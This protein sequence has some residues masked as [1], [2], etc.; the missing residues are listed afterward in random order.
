[1]MISI[2]V[3][4]TVTRWSA[5]CSKK[6]QTICAKIA[7]TAGILQVWKNFNFLNTQVPKIILAKGCPLF[8]YHHPWFSYHNVS[9]RKL[10]MKKKNKA[11]PKGILSRPNRRHHTFTKIRPKK[12]TYHITY[13][14]RETDDGR[15]T[16][17]YGRKTRDIPFR[18][19]PHSCA[20]EL[21]VFPQFPQFAPPPLPFSFFKIVTV[22]KKRKDRHETFGSRA[23]VCCFA[24]RASTIPTVVVVV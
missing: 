8:F 24:V 17:D 1:M 4:C 2:D 6:L 13:F 20:Q 9:H 7:T 21:R 15:K 19:N 12:L 16:R 11:Q 14:I 5:R 10:E 18:M 23:R 22:R 3:R